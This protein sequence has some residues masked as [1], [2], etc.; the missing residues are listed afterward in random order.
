MGCCFGLDLQ[1]HQPTQ[2]FPWCKEVGFGDEQ[3][4]SGP[5]IPPNFEAFFVVGGP[6]DQLKKQEEA[7]GINVHEKILEVGSKNNHTIEGSQCSSSVEKVP[8]TPLIDSNPT[9]QC[10]EAVLPDEDDLAEA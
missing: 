4:C 1:N 9:W 8:Q 3:P 10:D 6:S 2:V 7:L 5:A